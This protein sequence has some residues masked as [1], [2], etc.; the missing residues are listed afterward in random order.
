MV[1]ENNKIELSICIPCYNGEKKIL[2]C[3]NNILTY[4]GNDIEVIVSDNASDDYSIKEL[5]KVKD[6]RLKIYVNDNNVGPFRNWYLALIRGSG[7]YVMLLQDNDELNIE[8]L[9]E[10]ISFLS[11]TNY[12]IIRN[13]YNN[14][15]RISGAITR[16]QSQCYGNLYSH[17]SFLTYRGDVIKKIVP[18]ECSFDYSFCAYPHFIW[19]MQIM[20]NYDPKDKKIYINGVIE[21]VKLSEKG[22]NSRTRKY[23]SV[24]PTSYTFE[25]AVYM[26][27]NSVCIMSELYKN[28][29]DYLR[30]YIYLYKGYLFQGTFWYYGYM[31]N[32]HLK[33]RY[34]LMEEENDINYIDLNK[35][36]LQH[37]LEMIETEEKKRM[38]TIKL[39]I[40]TIHNELL[41]KLN[42]MYERKFTNIK[43]L[44]GCILNRVLKFI[45]KIIV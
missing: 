11:D 10:Y 37:A 6:R 22:T 26:F 20:Q 9:S 1:K 24:A 19:D 2:E 40:I 17:V 31:N 43:Y 23:V 25:N 8:K 28:K 16:A 45:I 41:F 7:R 3:V 14:M 33:M 13:A 38:I 5:R 36:F 30:M 34:G 21:I 42:Y 32:P 4:A 39:I 27:D 35:V 15:E 18:L 12:E 44:V 29:P